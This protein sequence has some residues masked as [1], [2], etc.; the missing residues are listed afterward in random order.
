MGEAPLNVSACLVTRGDVDMQ[1]VIDSIPKGWEIV[2][3]DNGVEEISRSDGWAEV[4]TDLSVYGRYAAIEHASHDLIFVQDDDVIVSDPQEI[5]TRWQMIHNDN[6]IGVLPHHRDPE[7]FLVANMPQEFRHDGYTDSCL[8]GFGACF[9][10]DL[11]AKAF[12]Q[13]K[14]QGVF[15]GMKGPTFLRT[16]DVVFTTL[17]PRVL[18]DVPKTDREMASDPN[19]MWKQPGH[20]GERTRMLELARKVRDA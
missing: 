7:G 15:D 9:H 20:L 16:C 1:P 3:W 11:P 19:R 14:G 13:E 6:T 5:V 12:V 10:R 17:T 2:I 4:C 8:V 18:V